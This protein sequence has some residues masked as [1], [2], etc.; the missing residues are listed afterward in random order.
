M[1]RDSRTAGGLRL[2]MST[3]YALMLLLASLALSTH[4]L[5]AYSLMKKTLS[6]F[7]FIFK[8]RDKAD[9]HIEDEVLLF[10]RENGLIVFQG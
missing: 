7:P 6:Q 8:L 3:Q 4:G 10:V 5:T 9:V 1:V 2:R